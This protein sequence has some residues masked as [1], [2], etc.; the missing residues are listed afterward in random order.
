MAM[1][2]KAFI[3]Y[4][5]HLGSDEGGWQVKEVDKYGQLDLP[6]HDVRSDFVAAAERRLKEAAL[7]PLE[8]DAPSA[9]RSIYRAQ[10]DAKVGVEFEWCGHYS[11][12]ETLLIAQGSKYGVAWGE[13]A[14]LKVQRLL[15]ESIARWDVK[16]H[17]ALATLGITPLQP[18]PTWRLCA[19]YN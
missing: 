7:P 2:S 15:T 17:C 12:C 6:W 4:G 1:T 3:V 11:H 9:V 8:A 5:Y 14:E 16:L 19:A 18:H 10:A 13:T